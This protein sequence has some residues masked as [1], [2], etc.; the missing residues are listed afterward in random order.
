M[1][2][3]LSLNSTFAAIESCS[4]I[5]SLTRKFSTVE[6]SSLVY[7]IS[8]R[9]LLCWWCQRLWIWHTYCL[10]LLLRTSIDY[11]MD[12]KHA[13]RVLPVWIHLDTHQPK[14]RRMGLSSNCGGA[15]FLPV[16]QLSQSYLTVLNLE[17][18]WTLAGFSHRYF[19]STDHYWQA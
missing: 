10:E 8:M 12:R 3:Y 13:K 9:W 2:S 7:N 16:Y 6:N 19:S 18:Y 17:V 11:P 4:P 14:L 15:Y 1:S 5:I